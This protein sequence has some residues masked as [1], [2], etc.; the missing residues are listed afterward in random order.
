[1]RYR[2]ECHHSKD[3]VMLAERA[4]LRTGSCRVLEPDFEPEPKILVQKQDAEPEF[5]ECQNRILN[6]NPARP[7]TRKLT[8]FHTVKARETVR[9]REG[10]R[11]RE[12]GRAKKRVRARE[13][14]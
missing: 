14:V 4:S 3:Q 5:Y 6:L 1:M 12:S 11:A 9:A 7:E 10:V 13:S 8:H 2:T